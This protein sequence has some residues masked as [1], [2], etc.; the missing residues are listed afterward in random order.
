[1]EEAESHTNA[2]GAWYVT[3][4]ISIQTQHDMA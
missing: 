4:L 3:E 1:M 2:V